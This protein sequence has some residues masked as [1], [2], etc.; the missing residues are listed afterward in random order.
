MHCSGG[1]G[2]GG[3]GGVGGGFFFNHS[4]FTLT[5][6][7]STQFPSPSGWPAR[8]GNPPSSTLHLPQCWWL[9]PHSRISSMGAPV[10]NPPNPR[11]G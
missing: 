3:G 9:L 10:A 4:A 2:G 1:S 6:N 5:M 11:M 7:G 8:W